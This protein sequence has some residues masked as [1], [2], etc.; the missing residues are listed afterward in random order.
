MHLPE[1]EIA[2]ELFTVTI[3]WIKRHYVWT[4]EQERLRIYAGIVLVDMDLQ[5]PHLNILTIATNVHA[6][7]WHGLTLFL[8]VELLPVTL[9]YVV[10][11]IFHFRL[12]FA[13]ITCFIVYSQLI[14]VEFSYL[15]GEN[16]DIILNLLFTK[17]GNLR[18]VSKL[19]L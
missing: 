5:W 11:L 17:S 12:T 10:V 8:I 3:T 16:R 14:V 4:F 9:F 19:I 15:W 6:G 18:A 1:R 2:T 13:P 7:N